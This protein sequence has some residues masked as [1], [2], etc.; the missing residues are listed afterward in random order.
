[1]AAPPSVDK[2]HGFLKNI[3]ANQLERK[4]YEEQA[5]DRKKHI[6]EKVEEFEQKIELEEDHERR[7]RRLKKASTQKPT[8]ATY[9]PP[10][11]RRG[12]GAPSNVFSLKVEYCV[13]KVATLRVREEEDALKKCE[14]FADKYKMRGD[15]IPVLQFHV[16]RR[17]GKIVPPDKLP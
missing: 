10:S 6:E 5:G 13:N 12:G 14:Q 9:V 15:L 16:A 4:T 1:M 7:L 3:I 8:R 17:L 11:Q 2:D